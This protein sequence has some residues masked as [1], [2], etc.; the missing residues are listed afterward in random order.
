MAKS[1]SGRID[2]T[3]IDALAELK[4]VGIEYEHVGD[5]EVRFCCPAHE[6]TKPSAYLNIEKGL[7]RCQVPSCDAAKGGNIVG[8]LAL[9]LKVRYETA[10]ADLAGRYTGLRAKKTINIDTVE[11]YH[12][13][14]WDNDDLKKELYKRGVTDALIRE[15]RLGVDKGR[16][17][18]PIFDAHL[19]CI[20]I[21]RYL[22]GAP[23]HK[24]FT[25]TK[26]FVSKC[27]YQQ[28]HLET[29]DVIWICGGELKALVAGNIL[30]K[31]NIGAVSVT[32]GEGAWDSVFN[33]FFVEKQVYICMDID[34]AGIAAAN[35]IAAEIHRH[36]QSVHIVTL[37]LDSDKYPTGD[38]NDWV[39]SENAGLSDFREAIAN[40]KKYLPTTVFVEEAL[41]NVQIRL[42]E[43]RKP[44]NLTKRL[45]T[46]AIICAMDTT[47]FL[48]AKKIAISC[49]KDQ[50]GCA[51]C[52]VYAQN[53]DSETG[54]VVLEISPTS[55]GIL[56]MVGAGDRFQESAIRDALRMAP[57]KVATLTVRS[58]HQVFD[59]RLQPP[60]Q[61]TGDNTDHVV[62]SGMLV[63]EKI[64]ELNSPYVLSGRVH[65][66][67]KNQ[68][69]ILL[70]DDTQ[71]GEDTLSSY[72]PTEDELEKLVA[73]Q[74][75]EWTI[76]SIEE[77]LNEYYTDIEANVT[78]I[79]QRRALH[80]AL[81]LSWLSCLYFDFDGQRQNGWLNCLV[82]GDSSQGKSE[83]S[84]TLLNH[85]GL[86]ARHDC[87]NASVA[88]LLG[89]LQQMGGTRW[90]VSWGVIPVNDRQLVILEELKG[91]ST[92]IIGS[93]T[94]MR[95]TGLAE[96]SK[97]EKRKAH[98]RTR[99]IMISNPRS[100]R[101]LASF[102]F[103]VEV[104]KEL[105]G[106]PE[107]IRRLDL[108][109]MLGANHVD[110]ASINRLR[111]DKPQIEHKFTSDLCRSAVLY[112]WTRTK[113]QIE[114]SNDTTQ[115]CLT[116]AIRLCGKYTEVFPLIDQGTMRFKLA[117]M[118]IALAVRTF[119]VDPKDPTVLV[120]RPCHV[121]YISNF[122]ETEY[123]S[124]VFGYD[125]YTTGVKFKTV[126]K[127]PEVVRKII[128]SVRH[129]RDVVDQ[130]NHR[131]E[132]SVYDIA[133][134]CGT[135]ISVAQS[136]LSNLVRRHAIARG[137]RGLYTKNVEFIQILKQMNK[138][139]LP[140]HG[141]AY[142]EEKF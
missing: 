114:L 68:Q 135:D 58:M 16:I 121:Q 50:E 45:T 5:D 97:I 31:D 111:M 131:D 34:I 130:L 98:A 29:Y 105:I 24:K 3:V 100:S 78:R 14:I 123:D 81:D 120:V 1:T 110:S 118:A 26:G 2:I 49:T 32:A 101:P 57:C 64:L 124:D 28:R 60:M 35:K 20:N 106:T 136:I 82:L 8:L 99:I 18:I 133:D 80:L 115:E 9:I 116:H 23:G 117:R 11:Q 107:D 140:D 54:Q 77:K 55:K 74:P 89:G 90:F 30:K 46:D 62:Q 132:F 15:A 138:E 70:I 129:P 38:I 17:T 44:E 37:P 66:S 88:G 127:D 43:A 22:P 51:H 119:S 79:Y 36:V 85:Y 33:K 108:V 6:D 76:E 139:D 69:A 40:A 48:V 59:T 84:S 65:P 19:R 53:G 93:L 63:T 128:L 7:W 92:D 4:R 137:D 134:W 96:I 39:A 12:Q 126:V 72:Q 102:S 21:R 91:A 95:S 87:K 13:A 41:E 61:C 141:T 122:L 52:N 42:I 67:P 83:A 86:G 94:D 73:F 112:A 27:I 109:V 125:Q 25:S 10:A 75:K 47:P 113:E 104:V 71:V 103:G 56:S 142:D